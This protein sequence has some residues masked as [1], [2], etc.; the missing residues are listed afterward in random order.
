MN[1]KVMKKAVIAVILLLLFA[2]VFGQEAK[3]NIEVEKWQIDN[4]RYIGSGILLMD[5]G[6]TLVIT[7]TQGFPIYF[8]NLESRTIEKQVEIQG[9]YAGPK[10]T[11][12][13][14]QNYILLQQKFYI[15]YSP[16]RDREV[17]YEVL[18]LSDH[19]IFLKVQNA[20][21]A[22]FTPDEKQLVTLEG[23]DVCIYD[24][25]SGNKVKTL[26]ID[27]LAYSLVVSPDGKSLIIT[28]QPTEEDLEAVPSMRSDRKAIKPA[29]KYRDLI[30]VFNIETGKK[31]STVPEVYDVVYNMAY[32]DD[33]SLL[34]VY[35]RPHVKLKPQGV[36]EGYLNVIRVSDMSPMPSSYM[37]REID[38]D[39]AESPDGKHIAIVSKDRN[40][41]QVQVYNTQNNSMINLLDLS[42]NLAQKLVEQEFADGRTYMVWTS[43]NELLLLYGN[44][45]LKWK[46]L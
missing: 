15:D 24:L 32:N 21:S 31:L 12:S 35:A 30:S 7:N 14:N 45:L 17:Q 1:L 16:N 4:S 10:P 33:A 20:H 22:A 8:Y 46:P 37:T 26:H 25:E 43:N 18:R 2:P 6:K 34:Y 44:Q 9:Y 23:S 39:F 5:D 3:T 28:H 38:A 27:R 29:I 36:M 40:W 11:F 42:R 41:P 13:K 19:S